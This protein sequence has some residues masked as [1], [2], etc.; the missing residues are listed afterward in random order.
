MSQQKMSP[1]W[2]QGVITRFTWKWMF[3]IGYV[4]LT[5][6]VAYAFWLTQHEAVERRQAVCDGFQAYTTALVAA[7]NR[8]PPDEER[9]GQI[10]GFKRLLNQELAPLECVIR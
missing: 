9:Q 2:W 8:T 6:W 10:D 5:L 1:E 4:F 7:S 3:T